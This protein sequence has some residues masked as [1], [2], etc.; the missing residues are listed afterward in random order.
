MFNKIKDYYKEN[1][2][3]IGIYIATIMTFVLFLLLNS[4]FDSICLQQLI[5]NFRANFYVATSTIAGTL[6]GFIITTISIIMIFMEST[7]LKDLKN[8]NTKTK[9][10]LFKTFTSTLSYLFLFILISL[11][12]LIAP[13]CLNTVIFYLI[14]WSGIIIIIRLYYCLWII[15]NLI[16][17]IY[18]CF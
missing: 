9:K 10:D 2:L 4:L 12:G 14:I 13:K 6:F 1:F 16:K 8:L 17:I 15:K 11:F 5:E 3:K 18:N 7:K